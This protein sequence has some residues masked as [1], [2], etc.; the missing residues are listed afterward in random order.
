MLIIKVFSIWHI[1]GCESVMLE[2]FFKIAYRNLLKNKVFSLV[3]IF[4]LAI[5]MAA[6]FFIFAYVHFESSYDSWHKDAADIYRV[7]ISFGGSFAHGE[8]PAMAT[9]HPAVGAAMVKDFPQVKAYARVVPPNIL[10]SGTTMSYMDPKGGTV[11]FNQDQLFLADPSFLRMF[12][13]PFVEGDAAKALDDGQA[14][15]LSESTAKKY[16]GTADPMGKT[17]TF[18]GRIPLKVTGIFKDVPENSHLKFDMLMSLATFGGNDIWGWPEFYTYVQ[19]APGTDPRTV[20]ARF[21]PFVEHYLG[22]VQRELDFQTYFHLQRLTDIHLHSEKIKGPEAGGS[23]QEMGLLALIGLLILVI[24]WINYINLSTAKSTERAKEVGLRKVVG[25]RRGQIIGQFLL[26]SVLLNLLALVVGALIVWLCFPLFGPFIGKEIARGTPE[27]GIWHAPLFWIAVVS[28]YLVSALVVGAYPAFILSA[29]RPVAVLKGKFINSGKGMALRKALVMVQFVLSLLL[30]AGS[31]TVYAQLS[32]MEH[33]SAGYSRDQVLVVRAPTI[34]DSTFGKRIAVFRTKLLQDPAVSDVAASSDIPGK[35]VTGRNSIRR[36]TDDKTHNLVTYISEINEDFFKA[37]GV[38]LAAGR[39]LQYLTDTLNPFNF[40]GKAGVVV[41]ERVV[42]S[43]GYKNNAAAINQDIIFNYGAGEIP[44]R[45]VGIVRNYHQRSLKEAY[46]PMLYCYPSYNNWSYF[47][48]RVST[49]HLPQTLAA[50]SQTYKGIFPG[51]PC[52]YFF[53]N[54]YFDRQYQGDQRFG[55]VFGLFTALAIFV[56]CIGL[57]GLSSFMIRLRTRETGIRKVLGASVSSLVVL[58]SKDFVRLVGWAT[59]IAVPVIYVG[60]HRWLRNYAFHIGLEW[61][62]LVAPPVL[63]L[64]VA[65]AV[66]GI[67]SVKTAL[68]NPAESLKTE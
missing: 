4:G 31:I 24:A 27:A 29:F 18:N 50:I 63:L 51:N 8:F 42:Q 6:C 10:F 3:N 47:S 60:A 19:L 54:E 55:K 37:Y 49:E 58:F 12:S 32:Y 7:N 13:Y 35:S 41:N 61:Y 2:S 40:K 68:A 66:V 23:E 26:E 59:V 57:L 38:Q 46:D 62:I 14:V 65:L 28:I 67:Q 1:I 43:L 25:G 9:N 36:A 39:N 44:A 48:V 15:V 22:K 30:I 52:D 17:L 11:S 64:V 16:F 45:I 20:E 53:L 33:A 34:T 21:P 5:G 56:A